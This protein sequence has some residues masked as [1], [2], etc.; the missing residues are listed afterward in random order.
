MVAS[1][2][3]SDFIACCIVVENEAVTVSLVNEPLKVTEILLRT[4]YGSKN[5]NTK[6]KDWKLKS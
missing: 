1:G 4:F 2:Q 5:K 6:G 3:S